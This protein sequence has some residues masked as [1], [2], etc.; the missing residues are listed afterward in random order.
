LQEDGLGRVATAAE[1]V[2]NVKIPAKFFKDLSP[3]G[4]LVRILLA[5]WEWRLQNNIRE[6]KFDGSQTQR[7]IE[8]IKFVKSAL[9]QAGVWKPPRIAF[10]GRLDVGIRNALQNL[11]HAMQGTLASKFADVF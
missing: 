2:K 7:N 3:S 9:V 8:M 11:I 6:W 4:S 1:K 5:C 10:A